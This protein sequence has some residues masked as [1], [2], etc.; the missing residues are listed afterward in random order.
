MRRCLM[1][2]CALVGATIAAKA[3]T[4]DVTG[5]AVG[6]A[7]QSCGGN[8]VFSGTINIDVGTGVVSGIDVTFPG[9]SAFNTF[10]SSS[11]A[12]SGA[13]WGVDAANSLGDTWP[14]EFTTGQTPSSLIGFTGG[15]I[16]GLDVR[17]PA[18]GLL[19]ADSGTISATPIPG[20]LVLFGT[21]LLSLLGL[22]V[23]RRA[24]VTAF[25]SPAASSAPSAPRR[26]D[27]SA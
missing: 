26:P 4:F 24:S 6:L 5:I 17:D 18:G 7:G 14:L 10:N 11:Q 25:A 9:L 22:I 13:D 27:R 19:F 21:A 23:T 8:C 1:V 16:V 3:T 15:T 12:N 20:S 2:A